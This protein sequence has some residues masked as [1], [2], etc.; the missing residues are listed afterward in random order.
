M[1][2]PTIE[3]ALKDLGVNSTY[4]VLP[5]GALSIETLTAAEKVLKDI[6]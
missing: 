2:V 1:D 5:F 4:D 6:G 3:D